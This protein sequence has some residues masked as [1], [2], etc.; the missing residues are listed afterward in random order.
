VRK[1]LIADDHA[2][3]RTGIKQLLMD[4]AEPFVMQEA[5][6][7]TE[8]LEKLQ[9]ERFDLILLDIAMPGKSGLEILKEIKTEHPKIPVLILTMFP[10]EQFALRALKSGASGYITKASITEELTKAIK[11]ILQGRKYLTETLQNEMLSAL[12]HDVEQLPH[13]ELSDREYQV[14][15]MIASGKTRKQIAKELFLSA[16]TI[17]T[18]RMRILEKMRLKT[19]AELINYVSKYKLIV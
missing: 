11:L 19:N 15:L 5:Q 6:D 3:V 4:L 1:I 7:G 8:V 14:M 18:Y 12:H 10:E 9:K 13:K 2:V 16:K 17:S